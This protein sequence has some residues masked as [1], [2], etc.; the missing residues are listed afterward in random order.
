MHCWDIRNQKVIQTLK[1][2]EFPV[3]GLSFSNKG[4][5]FVVSSDKSNTVLVYDVRKLTQ[6]SEKIVQDFSVSSSSYDPSGQFIVVG[7]GNQVSVFAHHHYQKSLLKVVKVFGDAPN[8]E[9]NVAKFASD[10][11]S[12]WVGGEYNGLL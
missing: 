9:V 6:A 8:A 11:R 4:T 12:L 3:T 1:N 7:G 2:E 10:G 5:S